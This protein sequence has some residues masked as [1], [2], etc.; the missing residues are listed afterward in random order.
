[1]NILQNKIFLTGIHELHFRRIDNDIIIMILYKIKVVY[2]YF[3]EVISQQ[4]KN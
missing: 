1:M 3:L 2:E 4:W